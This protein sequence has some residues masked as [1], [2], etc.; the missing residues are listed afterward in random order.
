MIEQPYIVMEPEEAWYL[1]EPP[2]TTCVSFD[3]LVAVKS[4]HL[5]AASLVLL[6][7][8]CSSPS[9]DPVGA[10]LVQFPIT[11]SVRGPEVAYRPPPPVIPAR[12]TAEKLAYVQ[13]RFGLNK[14]Q[15]AEA[16][17]VRRQTIYDWYAG[18]FEAEGKNAHRLNELYRIALSIERD[19]PRP[20]PAKLSAK[21]LANRKSLAALLSTRAPKQVAIRSA[22]GELMNVASS[23]R[24]S[25]AQRRAALGVSSPSS[26]ERRKNL[27]ENLDDIL[28]G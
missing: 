12:Q 24:P 8:V 27:S 11:S 5:A 15:L 10:W 26:S 23:R 16:C 19:F 25:L 7:L 1:I 9:V 6:G 13:S 3:G 20:V 17:Q 22:V 28:D 18:N 14:T 21:T 2:S 4:R